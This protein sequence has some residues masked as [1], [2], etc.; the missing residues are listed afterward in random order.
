MVAHILIHDFRISSQQKIEK[1]IPIT[2]INKHTLLFMILFYVQLM[3]F[4][5]IAGIL[6]FTLFLLIGDIISGI[7]DEFYEGYSKE[8]V[9][10]IYFY[11][12]IFLLNLVS[13]LIALPIV[14]F[15]FGKFT[16]CFQIYVAIIFLLSLFLFGF[17]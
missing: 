6:I 11:I 5:P 10:I 8:T 3:L 16:F 7:K 9:P 15:L 4:I 13:I 14:I 12:Y 2:Y 17:Y 1:N